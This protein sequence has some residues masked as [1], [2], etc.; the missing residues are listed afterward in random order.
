VRL[1][2]G[3]PNLPGKRARQIR[4]RLGRKNLKPQF[5]VPEGESR[6]IVGWQVRHEICLP[7]ARGLGEDRER[8]A[9]STLWN[10]SGAPPHNRPDRLQHALA[11]VPSRDF[12]RDRPEK[13]HWTYTVMRFA[14]YLWCVANQSNRAKHH[15]YRPL[16]QAS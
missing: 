16:Q 14:D 7:D 3:Y 10:T 2:S 4:Q 9:N 15:K 11:A 8:I 12:R 13:E 5:V 6:R 1:I